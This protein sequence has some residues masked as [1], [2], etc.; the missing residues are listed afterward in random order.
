MMGRT[1]QRL[2]RIRRLG[3]LIALAVCAFAAVSHVAAQTAASYPSKPVKLEVGAPAGGGT[4][5]VARMLGDKLGESM[6]QSFVVDNRPGASNTIAADFTAKSP[7]DGY[8][9]LVAT[10]TGQ[11]IAPHLM[12]LNFDT[13]KD[14]VPI[15]LVMVVPNVLIV[16]P[17]VT[18]K[19]VR[20]LV[21]QM[22]AKPEAFNYASSGAGSTQHL[23]GEAFKK[24]AGV[25][26]THIPYKGSSQAHADMLGGQ[27]QIMFDTTSSAIGQ[28]KSGKLRPLAVTS[29]K[30]SP[31]L[32]DVP[33]LAEA[34][35]PGLEMTTWY[36]VF[37]PAGTP[38]DVVARLYAEISA[39]LKSPDVQK[40]IAG[41]AGEPGNMSSAEFAELNR[42]D[43]ERYGKLIREAGIKLE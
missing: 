41:L 18:A 33:T 35:Y 24:L 34:G 38:R 21:A 1:S 28:I 17:S 22:K 25:Q 9:L 30:R 23:A 37:A 31:E 12:R 19:D 20:E 36:G 11:A 8:T 29:P 14:L 43:Y 10:N 2:F 7:P 6:K 42:A 4:D 3:P 15:A 32:P 27:A 16:S 5:I 26:M 40:R 39:V 13:L